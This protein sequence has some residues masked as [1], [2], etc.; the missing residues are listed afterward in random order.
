M[1]GKMICAM[2][3]PAS[4]KSSAIRELSKLIGENSV[5]FF[6]PDEKDPLTPWPKAVNMRQKYG[7]IGSIT[8]FRAMRVPQLYEAYEAREHGKIALV[9]SYFDKLLANYIGKE[10]LDWFLPRDDSYFEVIMSMAKKDYQL[11]PNA[12]IVIFFKVAEQR[13]ETFYKARNREIDQD[14]EFRKQCFSLQNPMLEACKK[15]AF[16]FGKK[17]L[18]FE[19]DNA[20]PEESAKKIK[21]LLGEMI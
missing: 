2:G 9:D 12:D 14:V 5:S 20:S 7:F 17:L 3:I 8:W 10:G 1:D 13:W 15:Y 16:D 4:G 21:S 18:V 11:L 6:E 19:P